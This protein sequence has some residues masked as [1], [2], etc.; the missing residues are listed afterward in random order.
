MSLTPSQHRNA[1]HVVAV[2]QP[3]RLYH[4]PDARPV[5]VHLVHPLLVN[6][7][8]PTPS[9]LKLRTSGEAVGRGVEIAVLVEGR[10]GG[11]EMH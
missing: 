5:F 9:I 11:D 3:S 1:A 6:V 8:I 10:V 4:A 7:T 2:R